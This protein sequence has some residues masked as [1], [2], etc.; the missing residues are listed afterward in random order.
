MI[1]MLLLSV[2]ACSSSD[3]F[4]GFANYMRI[5]LA[6]RLSHPDPWWGFARDNGKLGNCGGRES[7]DYGEG[8]VWTTD[9]KNIR[10]RE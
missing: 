4:G 2:L 7:R 3:G 9:N 5:S 10:V 8:I 6:E 1:T